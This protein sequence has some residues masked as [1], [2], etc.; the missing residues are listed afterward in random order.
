MPRLIP[1]HPIIPGESLSFLCAPPRGW[2]VA[3][4]VSCQMPQCL[5]WGRL[6]G[7]VGGEEGIIFV[8]L[9]NG[10]SCFHFSVGRC[11]HCGGGPRCGNEDCVSACYVFVFAHQGLRRSNFGP[12]AC[13]TSSTHS[14]TNTY[15]QAVPS[16]PSAALL[17][18]A[19]WWCPGPGQD[20]LRSPCAARA[21]LSSCIMC[22]WWD[23]TG[24]CRTAE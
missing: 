14:A 24:A 20:A 12:H 18:N 16:L 8:F 10:A 2:A 11:L 13:L 9:P 3:W 17:S 4:V 7:L 23:L 15:T 6:E 19:A 21:G 5:D 22:R 1:Q